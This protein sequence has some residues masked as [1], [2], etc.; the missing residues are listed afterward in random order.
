MRA[1]SGIAAAVLLLVA[2]S[3]G[4]A[5]TQLPVGEANGVRVVRERGAIVVVF[6]QR[7]ATLYK[8]IAGRRV[9]VSCT[10][11]LGDRGPGFSG[12]N[13][14]EVG[15]LAPQRRRKLVTG[16]RTRGMDYCRVWL[17]PRTVRRHGEQRRIGRRLIVSVPL[18]QTGAIFL[19]EQTKAL[20]LLQ[21]LALA[22]LVVESQKL[23]GYPTY[24]Q[25][26]GAIPRA[27]DMVV[28]LANPTDTPPAG[29]VGYYSDGQRHLT[30]AIRSMSGRRLFIAFA[31]D[32][33]STNLAGH[34]FDSPNR[35]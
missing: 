32:V 18:T 11:L 26:V 22:S 31:G 6:T 14:G 8:R 33:L 28:A 19:D 34:I 3:T 1:L 7:A 16:D 21:V 29:T 9:L 5:Q 20:D 27:A 35:A 13:T 24:A 23:D 4:V 17:A 25:L 2:P 12:T 15:L 10:E 30:I